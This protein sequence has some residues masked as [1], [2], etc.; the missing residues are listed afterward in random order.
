MSENEELKT[1]SGLIQWLSLYLKRRELQYYV[2]LKGTPEFEVVETV[3][4]FNNSGWFYPLLKYGIEIELMED[5]NI[6]VEDLL[7]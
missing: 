7:K 5:G 3:Y 1:Y 4:K 2:F 6:K